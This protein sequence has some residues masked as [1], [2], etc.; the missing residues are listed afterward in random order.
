MQRVLH[1]IQNAQG[2]YTSVREVPPAIAEMVF[3]M[4][5]DGTV[6]GKPGKYV[7]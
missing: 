4:A 2:E 5:I 3:A 6:G 7:A 1:A